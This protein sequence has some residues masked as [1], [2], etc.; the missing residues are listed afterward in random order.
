MADVAVDLD[1]RVLVRKAVDAAVVLHVGAF[2]QHDAAEIATQAGAGADIAAG[3]DD[4]VAYQ[5]GAGVHVG[6]RVDDG[7]HAVDGVAG[8]SIGLLCCCGLRVCPEATRLCRHRG[9]S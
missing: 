7:N 8:H 5:H 6:R 1:H 9:R 2:L 4:H 3:A